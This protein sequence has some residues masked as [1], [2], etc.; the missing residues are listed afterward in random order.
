MSA[1]KT[2]ILTSSA[3]EV[4]MQTMRLEL[5]EYIKSEISFS[6]QQKAFMFII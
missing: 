2:S 1:L 3:M 4:T 6:V 5:D